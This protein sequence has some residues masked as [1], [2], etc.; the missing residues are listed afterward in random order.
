MGKIKSGMYV[1]ALLSTKLQPNARR[2]V[3]VKSIS[4]KTALISWSTGR[5][6]VEGH[7]DL[8]YLKPYKK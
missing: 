1:S 8:K 6:V 7:I 2:N 3:F 5:D 4:G